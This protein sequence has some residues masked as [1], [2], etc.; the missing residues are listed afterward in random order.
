M[1]EDIWTFIIAQFRFSQNG[2]S[3]SA[4]LLVGVFVYRDAK[5]WLKG[6]GQKQ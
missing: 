6:R 5:R 4:W 1:I 3:V 2:V